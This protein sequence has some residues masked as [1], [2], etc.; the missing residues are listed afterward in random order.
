[1]EKRGKGGNKEKNGRKKGQKSEGK[2][3][4]KVGEA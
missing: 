1:M 3:T 2:G 4:E